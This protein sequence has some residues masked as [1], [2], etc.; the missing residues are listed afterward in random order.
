M[1]ALQIFNFQSSSI[2]TVL[3]NDGEIWFV[4]KDVAL[5]LGYTD[6]KQA[7][8]LHCKN[9]KDIKGS[10]FTTLSGL[11]PQTTIIPESDVYRLTMKSTLPTAEPFQDWLAEEVIPSIRKTGS[12]S[13]ET[14]N[15][16]LPTFKEAIE[17]VAV[18]A[19]YLRLSDSSRIAFVKPVIEQYGVNV[20][21]PNYAV[22]SSLL[23]TNGSSMP[24]KSVSELLKQHGVK[25]SAMTFN[26][27]LESLGFIETL[28]RKSSKGEKSYKS[29]TSKGLAYGKNVV[30][31]NNTK[32][33][34]PHWYIDLF[35]E[36]LNIVN[37]EKLAA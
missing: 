14:Q 31:P 29:V 7:I 16:A 22:D 26:K 4:A 5:A 2:R 21:L 37:S 32:E 24:T 3:A 36:L 17:G 12:Y 11:H 23:V 10:N 28:T 34:Q 33:T 18:L 1:Q 8:S 25:M 13:L 30:S 35:S 20:A 15:K 9:S 19:D 27:R 6:T